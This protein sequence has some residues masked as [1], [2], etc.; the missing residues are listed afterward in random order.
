MKDPEFEAL[1]YKVAEFEGKRLAKL[2]ESLN[3]DPNFEIPEELHQRC[4]ATIAKAFEE[5]KGN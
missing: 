2:A 4:L 1:M 5:K 3:N